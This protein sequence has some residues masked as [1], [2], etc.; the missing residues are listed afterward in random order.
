MTSLCALVTRASSYCRSR[1]ALF[2][3]SS[4]CARSHH[5]PAGAAAAA[6]PHLPTHTPQPPPRR[7]Q[8]GEGPVPLRGSLPPSR[9]DPLS[10]QS[11]GP[12]G[13][14]RARR[15]PRAKERGRG[16]RGRG[17]RGAHLVQLARDVAQHH[18]VQVRRRQ[19][20]RARAAASK[21]PAS[22]GS[23]RPGSPHG[24]S[25]REPVLRQLRADF[26]CTQFDLRN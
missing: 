22:A 16:G 7:A 2:L 25:R 1:I 23:A 19:H 12:A 14:T 11:R 17:G 5:A 10:D 3:A 9:S 4:T 13:R 15:R 20:L 24:V 18:R 8:G 21:H 6:S 26:D